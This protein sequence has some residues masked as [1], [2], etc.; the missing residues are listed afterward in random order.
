MARIRIS[1]EQ[2]VKHGR[3]IEALEFDEGEARAELLR[4]QGRNLRAVE[5]AWN[6]LQAPT[7]SHR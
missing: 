1:A 4:L 7:F 6:C 2:I 5:E 3:T